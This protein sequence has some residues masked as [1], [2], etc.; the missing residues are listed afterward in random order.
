[1]LLEALGGEQGS[2]GGGEVKPRC[3]SAPKT[4]G[5]GGVAAQK[6]W[7]CPEG[8]LRPRE[9]KGLPRSQT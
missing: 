3:K 6:S 8:E 2:A 9:G 1:M 7:R 4:E 5:Q